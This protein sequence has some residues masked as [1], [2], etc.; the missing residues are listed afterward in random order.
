MISDPD[1]VVGRGKFDAL[2]RNEGQ[3]GMSSARPRGDIVRDA[4]SGP[5]VGE[6]TCD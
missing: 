6:I 3:A 4:N 5:R 1:L 2:W